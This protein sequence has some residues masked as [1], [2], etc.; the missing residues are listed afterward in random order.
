VLAQALVRSLSG[1]E[2]YTFGGL[3]TTASKPSLL[4]A[5]VEL[6]ALH[7]SLNPSKLVPTD[8]I[9][10][11]NTGSEKQSSQSLDIIRLFRCA[12]VSFTIETQFWPCSRGRQETFSLPEESICKYP[13]IP[14]QEHFLS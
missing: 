14:P 1:L 7:A 10:V 12:A 13:S 8:T 11:G 6:K 9:P 2:A 4:S 5:V 3:S